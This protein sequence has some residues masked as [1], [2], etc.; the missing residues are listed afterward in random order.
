MQ[1]DF[2]DNPD[3]PFSEVVNDLRT[4][5]LNKIRQI[6]DKIYEQEIAPKGKEY[7]YKKTTK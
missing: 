6:E 3:C 5:V 7:W 4:A 2:L 1:P